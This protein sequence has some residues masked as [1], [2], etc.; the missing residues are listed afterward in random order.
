M[1]IY[2]D[3]IVRPQMN[4]LLQ[5]FDPNTFA[6]N[7]RRTKRIQTMA[8]VLQTNAKTPFFYLGKW[9]NARTKDTGFSQ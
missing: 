7:G 5:N 3:W 6:C 1:R 4:G 9:T 2:E 8:K